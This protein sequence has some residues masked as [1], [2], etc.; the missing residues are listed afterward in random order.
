MIPHAALRFVYLGTTL[1]LGLSILFAMVLAYRRG[2]RLGFLVVALGAAS[3]I[4]LSLGLH[5]FIVFLPGL[6]PLVRIVYPYCFILNASLFTLGLILITRDYMQL[7]QRLPRSETNS[8]IGTI[9]S[10]DSLPSDQ[11]AER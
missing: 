2:K 1:I 5:V 4:W 7:Q 3:S 8:H 9:S 6:Y 11:P 10:G